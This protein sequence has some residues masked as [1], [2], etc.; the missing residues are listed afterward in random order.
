LAQDNFA[1][2]EIIKRLEKK[3]KDGKTLKMLSKIICVKL[4][5]PT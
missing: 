3:G 2:N 4:E 5:V 1:L